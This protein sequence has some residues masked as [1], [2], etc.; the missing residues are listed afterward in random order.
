MGRDR[1]GT[2][3]AGLKVWFLTAKN[4]VVQRK[5]VR[6]VVRTRET[7]GRDYTILLFDDDLPDSIEPMR[8]VHEDDLF[9]V[10]PSRYTNIPGAPP[11]LLFKTDQFGKVSADVPGFIL[12]TMK[13]GDSGCPNMLPMPGELVFWNGRTTSGVSPEMQADMDKLCR[14]QKLNPAKYQLQYVDLSVY[15]KY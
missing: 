2:E 12:D 5:V 3:F 6:E 7:S 15:P 4:E 1:I 10:L 13:A 8:V 14:L 9:G 11:C